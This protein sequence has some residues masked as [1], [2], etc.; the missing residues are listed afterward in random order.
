MS[1]YLE[2]ETRSRATSGGVAVAA[3]AAVALR[4]GQGRRVISPSHRT[5]HCHPSEVPASG[6]RLEGRGLGW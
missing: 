1:T 3:T 2:K 5:G 4:K 6:N